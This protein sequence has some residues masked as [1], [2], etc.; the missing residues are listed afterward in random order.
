MMKPRTLDERTFTGSLLRLARIY[1][2]EVNRALAEH[3]LSDA[4]ALPVLQIARAGGGLRQ[5]VLAEELGVE[6]PSLV[7]ILDQ[8]CA[9]SLVERRDD[10]NDRRAK[11]LHLTPEGETLAVVVEDAVQVVRFRVLAG[12]SDVNLATTL[13]AFTA[14]EA[15]LE[16]SSQGPGS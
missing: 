4:K 9:A 10:P 8:L 7:R 5:G 12:V 13:R 11:T 15:A 2:R 3:G 1:R 6:G 16:V 14:F